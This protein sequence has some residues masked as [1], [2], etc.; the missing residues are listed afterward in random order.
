MSDIPVIEL[1]HPLP[2]FPDE[3][4]FTLVEL[5]ED[6]VLCALRSLEDPELR[7]LV[8]PPGPFFPD[9]APVVDDATVADLEISAVEDV[10]VL[11]VLTPGGSLQETTA[12]LRAPLVLN[13]STRR[14]CQVILEDTAL[15]VTTPLVA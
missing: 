12:N 6:G 11:L 8:A 5:D 1:V 10:V 14:A 15:S 2:G 13:T 4:R 3:R 7:F 9:Y